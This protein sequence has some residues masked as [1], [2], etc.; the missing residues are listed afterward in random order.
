MAVAATH[1][2][3]N[4]VAAGGAPGMQKKAFKVDASQK[5]GVVRDSSQETSL[6]VQ[7]LY[8]HSLLAVCKRYQEYAAI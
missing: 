7:D 5:F 4:M 8:W 2:K 6:R 1:V 3:V